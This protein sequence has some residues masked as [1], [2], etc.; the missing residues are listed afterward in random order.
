MI[1]I[2]LITLGFLFIPSTA[3]A[4]GPLTHVYLGS[5]LLTLASGLSIELYQLMKRHWQDYLY[6]NVMAD[7]IIGKRYIPL[8]RN[9]HSWDVA[10]ELMDAAVTSQQKAFVYG[11]MS[12][13][14]ADTVAHEKFTAGMKNISHTAFEIKSD[15][16]VGRKYW[17]MAIAIKRHIQRRNDRFLEST[18]NSHIFSVKTNRKIYKGALYLTCLT[19]NKLSDFI[20][21]NSI[22]SS[23]PDGTLIKELHESSLERMLDILVK[24]ECSDVIGKDPIE[25]FGKSGSKYRFS[26][27]RRRFERFRKTA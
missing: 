15:S 7:I 23:V 21:R 27:S 26:T 6:G 13:L 4:W 10:F 3:S 5:E 20:D 14:A 12:H 11:Y 19:P 16:L 25:K 17:F 1:H 8:D 18:L 22:S 9:S 2:V 24:G